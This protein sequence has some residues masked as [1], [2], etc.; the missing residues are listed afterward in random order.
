MAGNSKLVIGC[1]Y[2]GSEVAR[3][4]LRQGYDV[5]GLVRS[6][7][8][9]ELLAAE[10]VRPLVGDVTRR[11]T[12]SSLPPAD[13]VLFSVGR[14][15][16]DDISPHDLYVGGLRNVLSALPEA[17]R[18]FVLISS[19]GVFGQPV[20][21]PV[22]EQTPPAPV[23]ETAKALLAAEQFLGEHAVAQQPVVLRLAGIYGPGRLPGA[24]DLKAD[25]PLAKDPEALLNLIHVADAASVVLACEQA[26]GL[27]RLLLVSDGH[28]VERREFYQYLA[29]LLGVSPPR[30]VQPLA[31]GRSTV[32]KRISNRLM[33]SSLGC[34]LC[35]PTYR[36]GLRAVVRAE[37]DEPP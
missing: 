34:R 12:L 13:T 1:G 28:P 30:F 20:G 2:L 33:L 11:A 25:R 23:R 21:G 10:G 14:N 17:P 15:R 29:G 19:T 31:G 35:Y 16:G 8:R 32:S 7:Q 24:A 36:E 27:P 5:Y 18:C 9:A 37:C 3:R 22:D 4:W 26:A 6:A